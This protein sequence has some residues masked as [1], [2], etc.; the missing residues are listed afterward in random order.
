M[1]HPEKLASSEY[2]DIKNKLDELGFNADNAVVIGSG[3]LNALGIRPSNDIDAVTTELKYRELASDGHLKKTIKRGQEILA[4]DLFEIMTS[5]TV[6]G[7]AWNFERLFEDSILIGGVRYA[8]VQFMLRVKRSWV[9][10]KDVRQKDLD[11]IKL[12][13]AYLKQNQ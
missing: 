10:N 7:E 3:V 5:W 6:L 4:N 1:A 8:N 13:E 2:L 9:A 11:D 12:M